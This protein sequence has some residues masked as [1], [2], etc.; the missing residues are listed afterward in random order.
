[1]PRGVILKPGK[2]GSAN[3][4]S[5]CYRLWTRH[6]LT[7]QWQ[8]VSID[9][10]TVVCPSEKEAHDMLLRLGI[11]L[12]PPRQWGLPIDISDEQYADWL[13]K[14]W[15]KLDPYTPKGKDTFIPGVDHKAKEISFAMWQRGW[16]AVSSDPFGNRLPSL[17]KPRDKFQK[18]HWDV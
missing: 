15:I 7:S 6:Q 8:P 16:R 12:Y 1:M 17:R 4:R 18:E 2:P 11:N 14:S 5:T 10:Y 13:Q 3:T 9:G